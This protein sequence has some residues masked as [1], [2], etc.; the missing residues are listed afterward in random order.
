MYQMVTMTTEDTVNTISSVTSP[1]ETTRAE[2]SL[3]LKKN[4]LKYELRGELNFLKFQIL[5]F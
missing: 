2:M 4:K 1:T 5:S 3:K